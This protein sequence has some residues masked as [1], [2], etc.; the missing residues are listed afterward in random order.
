MHD[1][2]RCCCCLRWRSYNVL[3]LIPFAPGIRDLRRAK[4]DQPAQIYSA[5]GKLLAEFKPTHRE[6]VSLKQVSPFVID[7]LISTEDRRFYSHYGVDFK[8]TA[9][10][11]L[12]TFKGDKQGGSTITQKLARNLFPEEIGRSKSSPAS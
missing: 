8:R 4:I 10:A 6:W 2:A 9:S 12:H 3:V 11:A 5:D 7:A 1:R